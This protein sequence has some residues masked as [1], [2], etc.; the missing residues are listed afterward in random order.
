MISLT[1]RGLQRRGGSVGKYWLQAGNLFSLRTGVI[2]V[3]RTPI[4]ELVCTLSFILILLWNI[5]ISLHDIPL[6][7]HSQPN[8]SESH[9]SL[10][11]STVELYILI[12]F[13]IISSMGNEQ[14]STQ[15]DFQTIRQISPNQKLARRRGDG[16]QCLLLS[17]PS[18]QLQKLDLSDRLQHRLSGTRSQYITPLLKWGRKND[19]SLCG[20]RDTVELVFAETTP[21][22]AEKLAGRRQSKQ[23]FSQS[24]ILYVIRNI[25]LALRGLQ[26]MKEEHGNVS[27]STICV[28]TDVLLLDP[29]VGEA[30]Q[31]MLKQQ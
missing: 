3:R 2:V 7:P 21:T 23:N 8:H 1:L 16:Q 30:D 11:S 26:A 31:D 4:N 14:Q 24:E 15:D 25:A 12:E 27:L 5:L 18:N 6:I 28:N 17:L 22:L 13:I 29:I 10:G 20:N 9:Q 19:N